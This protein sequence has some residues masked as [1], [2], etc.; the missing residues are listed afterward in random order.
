VP[1]RNI[2]L[3][4]LEEAEAEFREARKM[5]LEN[6]QQEATKKQVLILREYVMS[7][8]LQYVIFSCN[9]IRT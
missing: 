4:V 2:S 9:L 8:S 5:L 1:S 3:S 6:K 7:P